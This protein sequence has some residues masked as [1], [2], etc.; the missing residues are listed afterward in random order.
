[1]AAGERRLAYRAALSR[2]VIAGGLLVLQPVADAQRTLVHSVIAV[3]VLVALIAQVMIWKQRGGRA[4][5]VVSGI[6]D[7]LFITF[8]IHLFG[9]LSTILVALYILVGVMNALVVDSTVAL[10][11][12]GLAS[13]CYLALLVAEYQGWLD[14]APGVPTA[15]ATGFDGGTALTAGLLLPVMVLATTT[16][17]CRL[18]AAVREREQQLITFN[19]QLEELSQRD[20]LTQLFNRRHL[21]ARIDQ[22]LARVRRDHPLTVLMVDLDH[23][24]HLNDEHGHLRGD[25]ALVEVAA[26]LHEATRETDV[27]GRFGGDEFLIILPDTTASEAEVVAERL[28]AGTRKVGEV[29]DEQRPITASVGLAVATADDSPA[30]LIRRADDGTYAVKAQGG[31]GFVANVQETSPSA[32]S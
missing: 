3:Y 12:S 22:E 17:V 8:L 10:A 4:R 20:P 32:A 1:M 5:A 18:I 31:D 14:Y 29:L 21:L 23:F 6:V 2:L 15:L 11:L 7:V 25:E 19:E 26:V 27:T 16:I 24:K 28:V 9:S 13:A 30:D